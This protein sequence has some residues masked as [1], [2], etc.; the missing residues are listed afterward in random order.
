MRRSINSVQSNK[1]QSTSKP[2]ITRGASV[3]RFAKV[4][5]IRPRH[6]EISFQEDSRLDLEIQGNQIDERLARLQLFLETTLQ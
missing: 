5:E 1:V 2:R 4:K 3:D 6:K